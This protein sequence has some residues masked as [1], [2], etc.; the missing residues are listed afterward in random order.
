MDRAVIQYAHSF[1]GRVPFLDGVAV[2]FAAYLPYCIVLAFIVWLF[3]RA[4]FAGDSPL[5][6][7]K[8]R[9]QFVLGT[10]FS[11]LV[12]W[13]IITPAI[14]YAYGRARPFAEFGWTPLVAHAAN[15]S[16]PS[17]HAVF[18]F[19]LAASVW[20]FDRKRGQWFL[21]AAALNAIARVYVLVHFPS[22]I[23][24]GALIGIFVVFVIHRVLSSFK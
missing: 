15:P 21:A 19:V 1:I 23:I 24:Y 7:K 5:A 6:R 18:F 4:P 14:R 12:A 22:D 8:K 11:L 10:V 20:Q 17:G 16:F 2:F 9:L 3:T 13:S